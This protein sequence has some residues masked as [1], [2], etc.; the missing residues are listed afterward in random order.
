M[1]VK[2]YTNTGRGPH[3]DW[4]T[5]MIWFSKFKTPILLSNTGRITQSY[6][7][8]AIGHLTANFSLLDIPKNE[9]TDYE[10]VYKLLCAQFENTRQQHLD[11]RDNVWKYY[12]TSTASTTV[13]Y[14]RGSFGYYRV[15]YQ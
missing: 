8:E 5:G 10:Y 15:T 11:S 7:V 4:A 14:Y 1:K 2:Y 3:R 13:S 9:Y 12:Y 6:A